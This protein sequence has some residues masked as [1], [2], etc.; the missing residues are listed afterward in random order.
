MVRHKI[1]LS[2]VAAIAIVAMGSS[3]VF[4]H[5]GKCCPAPEA[6]P[7]KELVKG[8][9]KSVDAEKNS[10]TVT[11]GEGDE[12]KDVTVRVCPKAKIAVD[13]KLAKLADVKA[14]SALRLCQVKSERKGDMVAVCITV[15]DGPC[16]RQCGESCEGGGGACKVGGGGSCKV[17]GGA[18]GAKEE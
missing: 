18:C 3:A 6:R 4:A 2:V 11:V 10:V 9:V 8:T 7:A 15:G 14:G 17:G 12:A 13:G 5:C 1:T 16:A